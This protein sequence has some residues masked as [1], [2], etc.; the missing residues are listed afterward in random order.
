MTALYFTP[1]NN[2]IRMY[3]YAASVFLKSRKHI[4]L[5][6]FQVYMYIKLILTCI[7]SAAAKDE[8]NLDLNFTISADCE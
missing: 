8:Q 3:L 2:I 5:I 1:I 7:K 6:L 4:C